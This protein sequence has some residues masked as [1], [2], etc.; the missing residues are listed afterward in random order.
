MATV[1]SILDIRRQREDNTYPLKIR[2]IH[3]SKG[4]E[5]SFHISLLS[6]F[7]NAHKQQVSKSYPN[8]NSH[9]GLI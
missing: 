2:I 6:S 3:Q 8:Y 4:R 9:V 1:K 5:F 7:W